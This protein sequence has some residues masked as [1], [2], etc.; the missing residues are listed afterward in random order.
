MYLLMLDPKEKIFEMCTIRYEKPTTVRD[1]I[2]SIPSQAS[3]PALGRMTYVG[4][5]RPRDGENMTDLSGIE[6][7][8]VFVA[9]PKGYSPSRI[10]KLA[11]AAVPNDADLTA[12][13][14][15]ILQGFVVSA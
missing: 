12:F 13:I 11:I 1:T 6:D 3:E 7:G 2:E 8:D 15:R 5:V 4:L 9:V 14:H 10:H